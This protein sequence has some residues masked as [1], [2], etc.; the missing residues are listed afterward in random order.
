[1]LTTAKLSLP[2][3]KL[4]QRM[5]QSANNAAQPLNIIKNQDSSSGTGRT[6]SGSISFEPQDTAAT[7]SAIIDTSL[8]RLVFIKIINLFLVEC[9]VI[10]NLHHFRCSPHIHFLLRLQ[11]QS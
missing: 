10:S 2:S 4:S 11:S 6:A 7:A 9:F 1:M 8:V 3:A 5:L